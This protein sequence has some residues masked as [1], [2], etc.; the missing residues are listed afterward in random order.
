MKKKLAVVLLAASLLLG[1]CSKSESPESCKLAITY[2]DQLLAVSSRAFSALGRG[3]SAYLDTAIHDVER[4]S[5][6]YKEQKRLCLGLD[7]SAS[8]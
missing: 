5:P 2:A 8:I 7:S 4:I 1:G 3:D 6:M